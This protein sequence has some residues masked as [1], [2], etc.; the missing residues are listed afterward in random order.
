M[1]LDDEVKQALEVERIRRQVTRS[2]AMAAGFSLIYSS[3]S[4]AS[5]SEIEV[6]LPPRMNRKMRRAEKARA[7]KC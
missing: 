5:P 2:N 6:A 7:R 4:P 1:S 3:I